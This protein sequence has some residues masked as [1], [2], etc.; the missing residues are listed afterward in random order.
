MASRRLV[1]PTLPPQSS[2]L[3]PAADHHFQFPDSP[4]SLDVEKLDLCIHSIPQMKMP[5]SGCSKL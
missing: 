4:K 1:F 3:S 2:N 5:H